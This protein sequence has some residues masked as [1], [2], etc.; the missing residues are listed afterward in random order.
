MLNNNAVDIPQTYPR[1]GDSAPHFEAETTHG[2]LSLEDFKGRW[3]VL[4]S[5][6]MDFT[7]VCTSEFIAFAKNAD[8]FEKMGA[9]LLGLSIDSVFSHIA[10]VRNVKEKFGVSIPFPIIADMDG[11]IANLYGMVMPGDLST[12]TSRCLFVIDPNA[13]IRATIYYPFTTGRNIQEVIR[14]VA[15]L[16]VC[17]ENAV[18]TPADWQP[19]DPVIQYPP[20]TQDDAEQVIGEDDGCMDW[21]YCTRKL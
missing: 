3:L 6:P 2:H 10:W 19:G 8:T 13:I 17:D 21:Y 5:H 18:G 4:F 16:Q 11:H 7:P 15:A 9:A 1:I 12:A 20:R 14:L